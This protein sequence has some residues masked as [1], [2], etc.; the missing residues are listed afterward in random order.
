MTSEITLTYQTRLRLDERQQIILGEYASLLSLVERSLYAETAKGKTSASCKNVFLKIYGIT[1]RQFNACRISLEGKISACK[2]SICQAIASLKQQLASLGKKIK[3]LEK[4]PSKRL[5]LHQKKRRQDILSH[6][7]SCLEDNQNQ[8][9]VQLC[10]GSRKLF[11]AQFHLEKNGFTS[12]QQWKEA[13]TTKRN[14]EFFILGSKDETAG[15]QTCIATLKEG[16]LSLRL[17]L[18]RALEEKFGKYLEIENVNFAYGQETILANLNHPEALSYR[19]KKDG[20]SWKVF[21]STAFKKAPTISK[22]NCGVIGLDLNTDHIAYVETDRF[23]NPVEKKNFSW[24][25]YG[26]SKNQLKA[27]TEDLCNKIVQQAKEQQKPI[28]IEKLD[29]QKKKQSLEEQ[30]NK[31]FAR[32]L[33][34]FAYGF[35][36]P[37]SFYSNNFTQQLIKLQIEGILINR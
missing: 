29:F 25:T 2:A 20:K 31:K 8:G 36:P 7:L 16:T 35:L 10:F 26:K 28:V 12:H 23:G 3:Q 6:K 1:A 32:L 22:E 34:S 5:V 11:R 21:V 4:K 24:T 9:R 37:I 19:F 33:S 13:W 14:S 18:P 17:R 30:G 27:L 15:N